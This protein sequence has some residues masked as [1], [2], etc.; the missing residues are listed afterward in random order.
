MDYNTAIQE[1]RSRWREIIPYISS[2]AKDMVNGETSYICPLCGH[3]SHGDG[4][5]RNPQSKDGNALKCFG[6]G[7]SGDIIDLVKQAHNKDF[8]ASLEECAYYIGISIERAVTSSAAS[9]FADVSQSYQYTATTPAGQPA[10]PAPDYSAYFLQAQQSNTGEYLQS[11]GISKAIQD[12]F[13]IGYDAHWKHPNAPASV[14]GAPYVIF[15]TSSSTYCARYTG[16]DEALSKYKKMH[17]G[18]NAPFFG[19]YAALQSYAPIFVVEGETD[20]LSAWELGYSAIALGS[21]A[22]ASRFIMLA[23]QNK[24]RHYIISLDND[25][26]GAGTVKKIVAALFEKGVS[27]TVANISGAYK[28]PNER[29]MNDRD[30]LSKSLR[31]AVMKAVDPE[32]YK[33]EKLKEN[34]VASQIGKFWEEIQ[35]TKNFPPIST[36]FNLLDEALDGGL[37]PEQLV[38]I[39]AISSLGK[40]TFLLQVLDNM[41][42]GSGMPVLFFSLEMSRNEIIAKSISRYSFTT[43]I[44]NNIDTRN[45]KTMRGV[46]AGYRHKNYSK[47]E[48]DLLYTA[49]NIYQQKAGANLYIYEGRGDTGVKEISQTVREFIKLTGTRPIVFIDYLQILAPYDV[50]MTDKQNTDIAVKLLKQLARDESIAIAAISS[51]NRENYSSRISMQA[52]KESGAIEYS[53][54]ILIGL[55]LKGMGTS[56]FDVNE[57]KRK[58]PREVELHILKNRN[59]IMSKPILYNYY[60]AFNYYHEVAYIEPPVKEEGGKKAKQK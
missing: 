51:L 21:V 58:D 53:S 54:D 2:P 13:R 30:G 37:F 57:A 38:F 11:R 35:Y 33:R 32:S 45:A 8:N 22:N 36:G 46:I 18:R 9:D 24:G 19:E 31:L 59:G 3:G 1:V 60:P 52:F 56:D 27:Y 5:T 25:G 50:K 39:G 26:A 20:A 10:S 42:A 43:A 14:N 49:S 12:Y 40:T 48:K 29:L 15:P 17:V 6:C 7:F 4:L 34:N 28:D 55:Q 16:T 41:A 44:Q 47:A 23:E